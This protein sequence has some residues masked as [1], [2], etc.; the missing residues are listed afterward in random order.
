MRTSGQ[1]QRRRLICWRSNQ[2]HRYPHPGR[3]LGCGCDSFAAGIGATWNRGPLAGCDRAADHGRVVMQ[4]IL[5]ASPGSDPRGS[6]FRPPTRRLREQT[7]ERHVMRMVNAAL[8][9]PPRTTLRETGY[10][11]HPQAGRVG[12]RK[13]GPTADLTPGDAHGIGIETTRLRSAARSHPAR[14]GPCSALRRSLLR[15]PR[16]HAS[17]WALLH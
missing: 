14:A 8:C 13:R 11:A 10:G 7:H 17:E 4:P 12:G 15:P 5:C 9:A 3:A 2:R 6:L 16:V 1:R